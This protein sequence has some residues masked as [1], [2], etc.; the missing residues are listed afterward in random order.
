MYD[1]RRVL[2]RLA[3]ALLLAPTAACPGGAPGD[4]GPTDAGAGP[5]AGGPRD[6][7]PDDG[8]GDGGTLD[9]G[10][11]DAGPTD[12]G[13]TGTPCEV[14]GVPG[15]CEHVDDCTGDRGPT[16]G[17]CPGPT[18]I[19]CCTPRGPTA[20]DPAAMPTPNDGLLEAPGTGGCPAGMARVDAF[21]IDR[22]E[23][24]LERI[25]GGSW[26]PFHD[27]GAVPVRAVSIED[28]IPQGY[29]DGTRAAAA[30]EAAGKRLCTD[31]EWLRA[32]RGEGLARL[33]PYEGPRVEGTC[34]DARDVH[35]AYE[36][37][38]TTEDWVFSRLDDACINQLPDSLAPTGAHAGC[39]TDEGVFDLEGNLHE[40]TSD[41]TGT[42]R[43]GFYVDT[44]RNGEGC[45]Y[46]TTAH[47]VSHRDYSTGFRCCAD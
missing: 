43:G 4:A 29:I 36:R 1:A 13:V 19:Q 35:P 39:V 27:P 21:C 3:C 45:L 14:G 5:D 16:P 8:G 40:W 33:H 15:T 23:A 10:A 17:R 32:C 30:C 37:F 6:G 41:P 38:G 25:G 28:A 2:A 9:G 42:F 7:G 46:R 11:R 31:D 47:D 22:F 24:S 34:N 26:S 44:L 18:E 20:C 12:A